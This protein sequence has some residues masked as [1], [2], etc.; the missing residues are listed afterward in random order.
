MEERAVGEAEST[1]STLS[2]SRSTNEVM[3]AGV[4]EGRWREAL[5]RAAWDGVA[6]GTADCQEP[7]LQS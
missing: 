2:S 5:G 3:W 4:E 7:C 1:L 6:M